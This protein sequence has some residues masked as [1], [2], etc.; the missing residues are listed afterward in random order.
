M[1]KSVQPKAK[2]DLHEIWQAETKADANKALD[3][4][5]EKYE[6]KYPKAAECLRK[7]KD[8][9][10]R[11]YDFPAEHWAHLRT[12]NPIESSFATI[13][14]R[15][16][17][18]KG[19]GTRRASLAM[20]FKLAQSASK[21]GDDY[22]ATRS[23]PWSSK[24]VPSSTELNRKNSKTPLDNFFQNTTIDNCSL[25]HNDVVLFCRRCRRGIPRRC[26]TVN[27]LRARLCK[28]RVE[29]LLENL[30]ACPPL[31]SHTCAHNDSGVGAA[32]IDFD[33]KRRVVGRSRSRLGY[34]LCVAP[35][36]VAT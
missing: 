6:A 5:L 18:T 1:P 29:L 23:C 31:I 25:F 17:K 33:F 21:N 14:L 34:P 13:R 35:L 19:N 30:G 28:Q 12:T 10:L 2:A 4:F 32:A 27:D 11:F 15:H 9:L 22:T 7:D 36:I 3:N 16:R 26:L 24:G 20:M 8:V